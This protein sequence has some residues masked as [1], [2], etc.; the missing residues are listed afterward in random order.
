MIVQKCRRYWQNFRVD[1]IRIFVLKL[2]HKWWKYKRKQNAQFLSRT[3]SLRAANWL[4]KTGIFSNLFKY[5]SVGV[6][7]AAETRGRV[8]NGHVQLLFLVQEALTRVLNRLL[9]KQ[10]LQNC[11]MSAL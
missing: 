11:R 7:S 2:P 8:D 9:G 3:S 10:T 5:Q 1:V 6:L 4:N